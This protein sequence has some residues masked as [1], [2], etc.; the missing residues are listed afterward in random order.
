MDKKTIGLTLLSLALVAAIAGGALLVTRAANLNAETTNELQSNYNTQLA[1]VTSTVA[2]TTTDENITG[3][4]ATSAPSWCEGFMGPMQFGRHG[5][6]SFGGFGM[7]GFGQIEV[8]D[9][10]KAAVAAI[11]EADTDVKE[12]LN[13]GYNVTRIMPISNNRRRRQY[14]NQSNQCHSY[15]DKRRLGVRLGLS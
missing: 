13:D 15:F 14:I 4:F 6:G 10:Y 5:R 8:S 3:D 7:G 12:L 1:V 9:E 11:A 2:E